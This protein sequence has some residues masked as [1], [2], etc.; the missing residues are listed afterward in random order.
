MAKRRTGGTIPPPNAP[1]PE[2]FSVPSEAEEA[3]RIALIE[4]QE[5]IDEHTRQHKNFLVLCR[6]DV[7]TFCEYVGRDEESG[8]PITQSEIHED[9]QMLAD[10]FPRL[11]V[12]AHPE[13]GKTQQLGILRTLHKLGNNRNLRVAFV[14]KNEKNA[15]K[16]SRAVKE[17]IEKSERLAEVFPELL[18]GGKWEEDFFQVR[19]STFSKDPSVAAY[20]INGS[21]IGSRIDILILDDI[22]D[23]ENSLTPNA[24]KRIMSRLRGTFFDRLSPDAVVIFL[25]NAWHPEDAAHEFEK[26]TA[27]AKNNLGDEFDAKDFFHVARFPIYADK[28]RTISSWPERWTIRRIEK[29]KIEMGPLEFAR[30]CLCKARDEGESPFDENAIDASIERAA[31][32]GIQLV[33]RC[34]SHT[35]PP[36]AAIFTGVDLATSKRSSAH[37]TSMQ[38]VM[39][40]PE[41]DGRVSFQLLWSE[42]G[43]WSTREIRDRV[44]DHAKRYGGIFIIEN[45]AAQRWILDIIE[46]QSDL[47]PEERIMPRMI[48]YHTGKRKADPK[49]GVEGIAAEI[50]RGAWLF[51]TNGPQAAA[52]DAAEMIGEM[53]Y[54][55]RGAH[56]GDRLMALW[57]ARE[58]MRRLEVA[59]RQSGNAA[60]ER[61]DGGS[62][63]VRFIG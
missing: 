54:Y 57:F 30:A 19:R 34:H 10:Y 28:E 62:G 4:E 16:S 33:Y 12:M 58:G 36:G 14:S 23:Q 20:G 21:P 7:N 39:L 24:R 3:R 63:N 40:W 27:N 11:I 43:R 29:K 55:V 37:L 52:K 18:P 17:Y 56:T 15:T 13:S 41:P 48:P 32:E 51:P 42:S 5:T 9:F 46:N 35:L 2:L 38:T 50:A 31:T 25:T 59:G 6:Q 61:S 47:D 8:K 49:F 26:E 1:P 60:E 22:L 45:N 44:L 53:K